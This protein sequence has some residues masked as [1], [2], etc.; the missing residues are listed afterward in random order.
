MIV[1]SIL[2][3]LLITS[4]VMIMLEFP[5]YIGVPDLDYFLK[6]LGCVL[7]LGLVYSLFSTQTPSEPLDPFKLP[8]YN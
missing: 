4:I 7:G 3:T 6:A 2:A 5:R 8:D 1:A